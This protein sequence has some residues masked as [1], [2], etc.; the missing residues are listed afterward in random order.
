MLNWRLKI[1]LCRP[2]PINRDKYR[3]AF[4]NEFGSTCI[5]LP[6][7]SELEIRYIYIKTKMIVL[8]QPAKLLL[9]FGICKNLY[10]FAI[11]IPRRLWLWE[12]PRRGDID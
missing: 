1:E 8:F 10:N 5:L 9:F 11:K 3:L 4:D 6:Y 12:K 2:V 7:Q